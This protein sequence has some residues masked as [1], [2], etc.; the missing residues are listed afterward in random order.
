MYKRQAG[1][2]NYGGF[3]FDRSENTPGWQVIELPF[4]PDPVVAFGGQYFYSTYLDRTLSSSLVFE[5]VVAP[6]S[7]TSVYASTYS[8]I[9]ADSAGQVAPLDETGYVTVSDDVMDVLPQ[10]RPTPSPY[11]AA[12]TDRVVLDLWRLGDT[13]ARWD[14]VRRDVTR[15]WQSQAAGVAQI[16]GDTRDGD[17]NCGDGVIVRILAGDQT[18]WAY[19]LA[20]G[21]TAGTS[22]AQSVAVRPGDALIFRIERRNNDGCDATHF[23]P[24]IVLNGQTYRAADD[25]R[26]IQGYRGWRYREYDGLAYHDMTWD[27]AGGFW[28]GSSTHARL[29]ADGGHPGSGDGVAKTWA[30]NIGL[31]RELHDYGLQD[32]AILYHDWQRFGY[33]VKLPSH[34][35]ANPTYG[36]PAEVRALVATASGFGW[37]FALHENYADMYPSS[38]LSNLADLAKTPD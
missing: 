8:R 11:R 30:A 34:Y 33:D 25:F 7:P 12:L 27:A 4:L 5:K 26:G 18:L 31:L 15:V 28:Q 13:S 14:P 10:P 9:Q 24:V 2:R 16:S 32:L 20:N 29:W 21:D 6:F 38:P 37:R 35:P 23:A 17:P 3:E 36:T 1:T 19:A 22:F